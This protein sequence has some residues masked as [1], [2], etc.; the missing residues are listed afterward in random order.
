MTTSPA[1]TR[2]LRVWYR[3]KKCLER[4]G[5]PKP[6]LTRRL[7]MLSVPSRV[8]PAGGFPNALD[9]ARVVDNLGCLT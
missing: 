5:A 6:E 1:A 9:L 8:G 7:A 4:V 3:R 2:C